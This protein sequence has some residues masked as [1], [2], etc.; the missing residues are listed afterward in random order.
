MPRR[1]LRDPQQVESWLVEMGSTLTQPGQ[2][3][4]IG[5]GGLLWHAAQRGISEGLP[6]N[7]MDVDPVTD[8]DE[9]AERCYDAMIGSEFEQRNGW[10]INLMPA[11]VL[12]EFP[13]DWESRAS[14]KAYGF[15][16]VV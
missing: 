3:I 9:I 11:T 2:L 12:R 5:S 13:K 8:S 16:T 1:E 7:S 14:S 15:L 4:L 6:E 10:H